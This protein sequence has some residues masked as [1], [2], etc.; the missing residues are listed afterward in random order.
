MKTW[1]FILVVLIL[2]SVSGW[3]QQQQAQQDQ[4]EQ[5]QQTDQQQSQQQQQRPTLGPAP[6]PTLHGPKTAAIADWS[7]LVRV[8]RIYIERIENALDERLIELFAKTRRFQ[9]VGDRKDADAI[10]RGTCFNARR[11]KILRSEVYLNDVNGASIWLDSIRHPINPPPL[12]VAV[13]ETA[14]L[15]LTHLNE[16]LIEAERR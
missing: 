14:T 8:K 4:E 6:A 16:S 9:I 3:T 1:I 10:L 5:A 13:A 12:K 11:L 7:K 2:A 15:I